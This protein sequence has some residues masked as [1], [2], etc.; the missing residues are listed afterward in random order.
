M[1]HIIA[2]LDNIYYEI[3]E[4]AEESEDK[5]KTLEKINEVQNQVESLYE[6]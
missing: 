3:Q 5:E 2:M 1:R 4:Y 6:K